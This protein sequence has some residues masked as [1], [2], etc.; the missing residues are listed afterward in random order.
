MGQLKLPAMLLRG[1]FFV[2]VLLCPL[3]LLFSAFSL[4]V[5][6]SVD[7]TGINPA[8]LGALHTRFV[9]HCWVSFFTILLWGLPIAPIGV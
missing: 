5:N 1:S 9:I 6:F 2:I 4:Y 7:C 8:E 3:S